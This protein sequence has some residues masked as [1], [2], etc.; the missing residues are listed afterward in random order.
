MEFDPE[1]WRSRAWDRLLKANGLNAPTSGAYKAWLSDLK[2]IESL[3]VVV[4]WCKARSLKISFTKKAGGV[5]YTSDKEIKISGRASPRRQLHLLLH[6]CGHCLIGEK[7]KDERF[8]MGYTSHDDP[9]VS[10]T[11]HHRL[12]I[13]EEEFEAWHRGWKL[14]LRIGALKKKD[15][16]DYDATR[17]RSL[18]TYVRW[19]AKLPGFKNYENP[20]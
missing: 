19:T 20:T 7:E 12:D 18:Y 13:L 15:K 11:V 14:A 5:Y 17:I 2:H 6:E 16:K 4:E 1:V 10:R 8:G 9:G 3:R